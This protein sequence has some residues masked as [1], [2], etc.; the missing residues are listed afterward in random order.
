MPLT[1]T[2]AL[3]AVLAVVAT[4]AAAQDFSLVTDLFENVEN[5]T[6][7][8][9]HGG[10]LQR[11]GISSRGAACCLNGA[12]AEVLLE[13]RSSPRIDWELGLGASYL[14][15]FTSEVEGLDFRG[16]VRSFPTLS[17]YATGQEWFGTGALLGYLG[18]TIGMVELWNAQAYDDEGGR[19]NVSAQTLELGASAGV[20]VD[21]G[22][23][24]GLFAELAYRHRRFPSVDWGDDPLPDDWPRSLDLSG[25]VFSLGFQF[26]VSSDDEEE[27]D[28]GLDGVWL[29]ERLDSQP[30]PG[31]LEMQERAAGGPMRRVELIG[32]TLILT[33]DSASTAAGDYEL[34]LPRRETVRD[35]GGNTTVS[36]PDRAPERGR[37]VLEDG[38]LR[39]SPAAGG[40]PHV[41]RVVEEQLHLRLAGTSH[42]LVLRRAKD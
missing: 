13:L 12:G 28:G 35:G 11:D 30:L 16:S 3:A 18:G 9:Q 25:P 39:L 22:F 2:F 5:V 6:I 10:V 1:R 23:F 20:Y 36:H 14:R 7:F 38:A 33:P 40:E 24:S 8:W 41:A 32:G 26:T 37:W 42:V 4:P 29:A 27:D 19:R 31:V 34:L 17:I 21:R 15:G